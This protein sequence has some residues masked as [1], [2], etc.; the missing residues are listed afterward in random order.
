MEIALKLEQVNVS[1]G[2]VSALDNVNLTIP[3]QTRTAIVGPN[4]AGKST[5]MKA[6]LGLERISSGRIELLGESENSAKV[7]EQKVAYI[8]QSTR[9]N[10]NFPATVFEIV[11]MGRYAQIT[12]FL[13][14]PGRRDKEVVEA[15]L[16][17]M[18]LQEVRHRQ[19]DQ[20]SGGQRQRVFIARALAQEADIYLMD[21]PL[22]GI[23]QLTETIIMDTLKD[24]QKAGKTSIVIHHDLSTLAD[25][26]DHLVWLNKTVIASGDIDS[27]LTEANYQKTYGLNSYSFKGKG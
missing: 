19:I 23:D 16:E 25:Y 22:A 6:I 10:W 3:K 4:G 8:P 14:R 2:T 7:V 17:R 21:E 1:Y 27:F 18:N 11:L 12:N 9:A 13:K 20:L 24:F 5:L 26:F 15:A